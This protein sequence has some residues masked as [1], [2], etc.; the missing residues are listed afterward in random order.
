MLEIQLGEFSWIISYLYI[1]VKQILCWLNFVKVHFTAVFWQHTNIRRDQ[2]HCYSQSLTSKD[3][4]SMQ[5]QA[6]APFPHLR[7]KANAC[8][9]SHHYSFRAE[10]NASSVITCRFQSNSVGIAPLLAQYCRQEK[11]R[12]K[13]VLPSN[14]NILVFPNCTKYQLYYVKKGVH[15]DL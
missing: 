8:S 3:A 10:S 9:L 5:E 12:S 14:K 2:S 1:P 6:H 7:W 4:D 13:K 11:K 15:V